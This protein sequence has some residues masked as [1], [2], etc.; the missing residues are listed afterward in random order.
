MLRI[1]AAFLGAL[2]AALWAI[3]SGRLVQSGRREERI[4]QTE[5]ENEALREQAQA[6]ADAHADTQH[7]DLFV[8]KLRRE[9]F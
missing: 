2:K 4:K 5:A 9:G 6:A 7:D 1:L 8:D 3:A